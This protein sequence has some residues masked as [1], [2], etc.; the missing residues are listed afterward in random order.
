MMKL[1]QKIEP[2]VN[3]FAWH[4][5]FKKLANCLTFVGLCNV[6]NIFL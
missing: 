3:S 2:T 6:R 1:L 4:S 5:V